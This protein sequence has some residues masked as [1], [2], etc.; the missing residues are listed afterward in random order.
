M[1][2]NYYARFNR[3][4]IL[5]MAGAG[6]GASALGI[7]G[8]YLTRDNLRLGLIGCGNRGSA[9]AD[10]I[11]KMSFY[12]RRFG[13]LVAVCD[14]N[15]NR[16]T[17][18][19]QKYAPSALVTQD[20]RQILEMSNLDGILIAT[21]N[22]WHAL[23]AVQAL[24]SDKAVYLE[25]PMTHTITESQELLKISKDSK[26]PILIGTQQRSTWSCRTGAELVRNGK[27]GTVNKARIYLSNKGGKGGPFV[28]QSIP[29]ELNWKMWLG[30]APQVDYCPERY[31]GFHYW[32]DYGSGELLN[33]GP[34]H[35]DIAMWAMD[36]CNT[37][38]EKVV[39]T[40][41]N[42]PNI[43]GGFEVPTD[44][45]A[46]FTFPNGKSIEITSEPKKDAN[47]SGIQFM[48]T[49]GELWVDRLN[50]IGDSVSD[51]QTNPFTSADL[52]MQKTPAPKTYT[53]VRHLSHFFD[54][55]RGENFPVSDVRST[56]GSNVALHLAAIS[57]RTQKTILWDPAN[58][59]LIN[60]P[61]GE[62]YLGKSMPKDPCFT[63]PNLIR[64]N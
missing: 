64:N 34:H 17:V 50:I 22:H 5:T 23:M 18:I 24:N 16:A 12:Y 43:Q 4:Q 1:F 58:E 39:C 62:K 26:H 57:L 36:L 38:P 61:F 47:Q 45:Q 33:W 13:T 6:V 51:L 35:M 53:T 15:L 49:T 8:Y 20:Y 60:C 59:K 41:S 10:I 27:V 56:H 31:G 29:P 46:T 28:K 55:A 11:H 19:A 2:Y 37:G 14:A 25:K 52:Q 42:M 63:S 32:W 54:V 9:L 44:F 48:G 7:G 21:P 3:R 30:P 40:T